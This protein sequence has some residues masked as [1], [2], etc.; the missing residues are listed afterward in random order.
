MGHCRY[1][2]KYNLITHEPKLTSKPGSLGIPDLGIFPSQ[3]PEYAFINTEVSPG[4]EYAFHALALDEHRKPFSPTI[5]EMPKDQPLPKTFR[6]CWFPGVHSNIGGSYPDTEIADI[7]LAWMMA[8]LDGLLDFDPHYITW[9][10]ELN[11]LY[12]QSQKPPEVKPWPM[13]TVYNSMTGLSTLGG[14]Q[15]RT[16]GQYRRTNPLTGKATETFL[17]NTNE[18]VHPCVRI[19]MEKGGKSL[20]PSALEG[21]KLLTPADKG[22]A[23]TAGDEAHA[24]G[25]RWVLSGKGGREVVLPEMELAGVEV[26]LRDA[27]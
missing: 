13:G 25:Y 24:E 9:Q 1:V 7:T 14:S 11:V 22:A 18:S 17:A 4:V 12:Y 15:V 20:R 19:R 8:Q 6:Q 16:P 27:A 5:W 2:R 21:W 23:T 3:P 10:R 26:T